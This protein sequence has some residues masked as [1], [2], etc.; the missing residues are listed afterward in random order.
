MRTLLAI[1]TCVLLLCPGCRLPGLLARSS[2]RDE[3]PAPERATDGSRS[4]LDA[5]P[6]RRAEPSPGPTRT[7]LPVAEHLDRGE[8]AI[9]SQTGD[10]KQLDEAKWHFEQV[11]AQQPNHPRA[12][13]MLAVI[14]DLQRQYP[15]AER[16]YQAALQSDPHN[17]A[18][19]GDL[20]YSYLM[21]GRYDL[22]EQYLERARQLDPSYVSATLN[23]AD[24]HSR[25]GD[26]LRAEEMLRQVLP[27]A[28]VQKLMAQRYPERTSDSSLL[29]RLGLRQP[30][31]E[32]PTID[33]TQQL[34]AQMDEARRQGELARQQRQF[35]QSQASPA[36][37][38]AGP[39]AP[40]GVGSLVTGTGAHTPPPYA[41]HAPPPG[42]RQA[43]NDMNQAL[44]QID[45]PGVPGRAAPIIIGPGDPA[46]PRGPAA[47][48]GQT[49][50]ETA[51]PYQTSALANGPAVVPAIAT[52]SDATAGLVQPT[53]GERSDDTAAPR[54]QAPPQRTWPPPT[55]P[56]AQASS[57]AADA[58]PAPPASPATTSIQQAGGTRDVDPWRYG[59]MPATGANAGRRVS[60]AYYVGETVAAPVGPVTPSMTSAAGG[61]VGDAPVG[62]AGSPFPTISPSAPRA[63]PGTG[64]AW[65]GLQYA[66]PERQIPGVNWSGEAGATTTARANRATPGSQAIESY[67][68]RRRANDAHSQDL[69]DRTYGPSPAGFMP[70][71]A[72]A[73]PA[74][75]TEV[76]Q[77]P[78][79]RT[80][81]HPPVSP[82]TGTPWPARASA[83]SNPVTTAAPS[84]GMVTPEPYR[85]GWA[86]G[87]AAY[88][89]YPRTSAEPSAV[90]G[91]AI[92]PGHY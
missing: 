15:A 80:G 49:P 40:A 73:T 26:Y 43:Y 57:A 50:A 6:T 65:N 63:S 13:H 51:P 30:R 54:A 46:W 8:R 77:Y 18:I 83:T 16:H 53:S 19:V 12:H 7:R 5:A 84:A 72:S 10:A 90:D 78:F 87:A 92:V 9:Q 32:S 91:P 14:S 39:A 69:I 3:L 44:A 36:G 27:E 37:A 35:A 2:E 89:T 62:G 47:M 33:A 81:A 45:L 28:E 79:A 86:A 88:E 24:L 23:L 55:W 38:P 60:P 66:P 61:A 75:V 74:P 85:S 29:A 56:P 64:S 17:A 41:P 31:E 82:F 21:Q 59:I 22:S 71:P 25:R 67:D 70:S 20:G 48:A 58:V 4:V 42:E 68:A 76:P 11:V 1:S 52:A 34:K